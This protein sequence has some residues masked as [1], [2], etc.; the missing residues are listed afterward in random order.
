MKFLSNIYYIE[1]IEE[2]Y[3]LNLV[4][5]CIGHTLPIEYLGKL[6]MSF[7]FHSEKRAISY[8]HNKISRGV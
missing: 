4:Q 5:V 1:Y 7:V 2:H 8:W 3:P 6:L